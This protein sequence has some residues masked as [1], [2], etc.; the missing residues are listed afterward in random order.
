MANTVNI[1][2]HERGERNLVLSVFLRSDG[3]SGDLTGYM[4]VDPAA[5][6]D[7]PRTTRFS[8]IEVSHNFA[9]FSG[10]LEFDSGTIPDTFKWVL[11]EHA[12]G[13]FDFNSVGGIKDSSSYL[14][15]TGKLQLSTSGFTETSDFGSLLLKL[16]FGNALPG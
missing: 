7:L 14:D 6:F 4:L 5:D 16:R 3:V 9:G 13:T 12:G 11:A 1:T 2:I 8:L 10:I 15:G